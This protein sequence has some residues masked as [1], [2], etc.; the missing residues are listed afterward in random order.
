[1]KIYL[2]R[3]GESV[4]Q[5]TDDERP[6]SESG[7]AD[8]KRLANL[9]APLKIQVT[10]IIHSQKYRAQQTAEILASGM[11]F[12][13]SLEMSIELDPMAPILPIIDQINT[14]DEDSLLV[15]HMPF[16][17]RLVSMLASGM[18]DNDICLFKPGCMVCLQQIE[19][20]RWSICWMLGPVLLG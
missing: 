5:G 15:G 8:I 19:K 11:S 3:H 20:K 6:L 13:S 18:E 16:M 4:S 7:M 9:I 2:A 12:N 14:W 1:M 17:G 10:R